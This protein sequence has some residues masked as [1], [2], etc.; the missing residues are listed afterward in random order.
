MHHWNQSCQFRGRRRM[1]LRDGKVG[2]SSRI[3]TI[4]GFILSLVRYVWGPARSSSVKKS[5]HLFVH[6]PMIDPAKESDDTTT[7][8]T[9]DMTETTEM[10]MDTTTTEAAESKKDPIRTFHCYTIDLLCQILLTLSTTTTHLTSSSTSARMPPPTITTPFSTR[11]RVL[12]S[13]QSLKMKPR[14]E[15]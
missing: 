15:S 9:T 7:E 10:A 3:T 1:E 8:T 5:M 13:F 2:C 4:S 12:S 14:S 6:P 11:T